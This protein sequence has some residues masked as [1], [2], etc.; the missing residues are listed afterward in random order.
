MNQADQTTAQPSARQKSGEAGRSGY[1]EHSSLPLTSLIFLA[2]FLIVYEIGT[3]WYA[4]DPVSHVEQR[5]IAFNLIQKFF[6]LFGASGKYLPAAAVVSVLLGCHAAHRDTWSA[7]LSVLTAMLLECMMYAVPLVGVGY[8]FEHCLLLHSLAGNWREWLVL[9]IGAG[10]YEELVFRLAMF[11]LLSFI[12]MDVL[13]VSKARALP[14]MVVISAVT[15]SLYHYQFPLAHYTGSEPFAWSSFIFRSLAGIYFG[16]IF[17]WRGF[18]LTA[19][20][21]AFYD[22]IIVLL[23]VFQPA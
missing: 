23:R 4:I 16:M 12:L 3:R 15:F 8:L 1:F 10:I 9:S 22:V 17:L 11:S 13:Q 14:L 21:H 7:R 6:A 19:G 18:G 2:P 20:S 5:I